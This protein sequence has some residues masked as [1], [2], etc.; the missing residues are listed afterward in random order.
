MVNI[1]K[2]FGAVYANRNVSFKVK[3]GE[4]YALLGENGAGKSTLMNILSGIYAPDG[5]EIFIHGQKANLSSPKASIDAGIGMIH[6]HFKLVDVLT[7]K[8]NVI[9]GRDHSFFINPKKLARQIEEICQKFGL[10]VDPDKKIY[11]MSVGEKQTVEILKVLYRGAD[12]LILDEPTA[13]LTPQETAKLFAIL[14]KMKERGCA[15]IIITHKMH[16]VL[17]ISD[18]VTIMRKG[19]SVGSVK[20]SESTGREL[21]NLMVGR[22]VD[23]AIERVHTD[24]NEC[25][26]QVRNLTVFDDAG[27]R[28]LDRVNFDLQAGE[29]LGVAG[30]AGS[31]QKELCESI[32][33]LQ[34]VGNGQIRYRGQNI[35]GQ[36][37]RQIIEQGITMSFIPEDRLGMGLVASMDMVDNIILKDYYTQKGLLLDRKPAAARAQDLIGKLNIQTPGI[38]HPVKQLSGG[39]IQKVLLGREIESD[40]HLLV[41]A[42][43]TRGLDVGASHVIYDLLNEQKRRGVGLLYVGEDLDVLMELCDRIMVLCDGKVTGVVQA[44]E[45]SKEEL[46]LLMAGGELETT[47]AESTLD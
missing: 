40:P 33:G 45:I 37:S 35:V 41:T 13:V 39:N 18:W 27:V 43:P 22:A 3:R 31:G 16:E 14:R 29:I 21:T 7:A 23:L 11:D 12:I 46:G 30:V 47:E 44:N 20:T 25:L 28:K 19:E 1:T 36:S 6:Q 42:Y 24:F 34:P 2:T 15:I 8:E 4:V 9:L 26:L 10:N 38:H 32:A 5:G 17:E